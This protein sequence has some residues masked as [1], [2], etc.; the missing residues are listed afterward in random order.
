VT[1]FIF[2]ITESET[3]KFSNVVFSLST[4]S[5]LFH[6]HTLD[7]DPSKIKPEEINKV[8]QGE[9][10]NFLSHNLELD[11]KDIK[12][13]PFVIIQT[14]FLEIETKT[15]PNGVILQYP[16]SSLVPDCFL[17]KTELKGK[18]PEEAKEGQYS[19]EVVGKHKT[20]SLRVGNHFRI[21]PGEGPQSDMAR[22][23][24]AILWSANPAAIPVYIKSPGR[25]GFSMALNGLDGATFLYT[26]IQDYDQKTDVIISEVR[27][28]VLRDLKTINYLLTRT[29]MPTCLILCKNPSLHPMLSAMGCTPLLEYG[30]DGDHWKQIIE[31][32]RFPRPLFPTPSP[33]WVSHGSATRGETGEIFGKAVRRT[34]DAASEVTL[35]TAPD[36]AEPEKLRGLLRR[37]GI[38]VVAEDALPSK[39]FTSLGPDLYLLLDSVIISSLL[40]KSYPPSGNDGDNIWFAG[41][42]AVTW[43]KEKRDR[44]RDFCIAAFG[45]L[46]RK[47]RVVAGSFEKDPDGAMGA[48]VVV[49]VGDGK[50]TFILLGQPYE[51]IVFQ[52]ENTGNEILGPILQFK[53]ELLEV[54]RS[55]VA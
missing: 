35:I 33:R 50:A 16:G 38:R 39:G 13:R 4:P 7:L 29:F 3:D 23:L 11:E 43:K 48:D 20:K 2:E 34:N 6:S 14:E 21:L 46:P 18:T 24:R 37:P 25:T 9:A 32:L 1:C 51:P 22:M 27:D 31:E 15:I 55:L 8:L 42:G 36:A 54:V 30:I 28:L 40:W 17:K 53:M 5:A 45:N 44:V 26:G 47:P 49:N 52:V 10:E 41:E 19:F 12:K